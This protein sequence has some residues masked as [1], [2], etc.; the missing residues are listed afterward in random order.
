MP[1]SEAAERN[2][3]YRHLTICI[4]DDRIERVLALSVVWADHHQRGMRIR[5]LDFTR[6]HGSVCFVQSND[7]FI[8]TTRFDVNVSRSFHFFHLI[9]A[10]LL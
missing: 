4:I 5:W 1:Q 2:G 10:A 8:L 3:S 9:T 7:H 6:L